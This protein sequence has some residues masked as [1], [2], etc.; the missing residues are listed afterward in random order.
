MPRKRAIHNFISDFLPN[1]SKKQVLVIIITI[2]A[3]KINNG[4]DGSANNLYVAIFDTKATNTT[5]RK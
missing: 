2:T 1:K 5:A 4:I 3:A